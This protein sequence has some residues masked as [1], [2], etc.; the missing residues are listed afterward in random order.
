MSKVDYKDANLRWWSAT[1][2][3]NADPMMLLHHCYDNFSEF[4]VSDSPI[5]PHTH[6]RTVTYLTPLV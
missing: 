5:I 3:G 1:L 4:P 6:H 2:V